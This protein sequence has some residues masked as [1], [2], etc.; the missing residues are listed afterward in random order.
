[1]PPRNARAPRPVEAEEQAPEEQPLSVT[2]PQAAQSAIE[3]IK[4]ASKE[5]FP[6]AP[7]T[8]PDLV[9]LP[10]GVEVDGRWIRKA[11]VKELNGYDEEKIFRA[12]NSGNLLH[13][14][15]IILECGTEAFE[16]QPA[17][18]THQLLKEI[19]IGDREALLLGIRCATYD[20]V[21]EITEWPCPSCDEPVDISLNIRED[22]KVKKSDE[23]ASS[24]RFEVP[25]RKGGKAVVR[26]PNG[27]DQ[28]VVG[29]DPKRNLKERNTILLQRCIEYIEQPNGDKIFFSAFPT[30]AKQMGALD[31][32]NIIKAITE[33]QPRP[34]YEDIKFLHDSCGKEVS[35]SLDLAD[36]FLRLWV[37]TAPVQ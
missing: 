10:G 16:G 29:E 35:L 37:A 6:D 36:L 27:E 5:E 8:D 23:A 30:Y 31:R 14:M 18:A 13:V 33:R 11:R 17:S 21:V 25:L 26:L 32:E 34:Q 28:E 7:E 24:M 12:W 2:D 1:M 4:A 15:N 9:D 19:V 3:A 20:D 22:V